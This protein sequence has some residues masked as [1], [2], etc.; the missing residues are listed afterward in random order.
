MGGSPDSEALGR[1]MEAEM[2]EQPAV[3]RGLL[4]SHTDIV[5]RVRRSI[6]DPVQ[7]IV[8]V[9]RGSSDNAAVF[10]RYVLESATL[11]PVS[12]LFPSLVTLYGV[13]ADYR[14]WV[15]IGA[16]QSGETPEIVESM[17]RLRRAGASAVA[18]TNDPSSP[19][20]ALSDV[21]VALGAG[22]EVAVPATKT[23]TS[24]LA[25]F[26]LL[27]EAMG[28]APWPRDALERVPAAVEAALADF[29]PV[30]GAAEALVDAP[31]AFVVGRGYML[32]VALEAALK[33]KESAAV[34]AEGIS[35][36]DLMHGPI[37][38]VQ[39]HT[40][41]VLLRAPGPTD[42]ELEE[43]RRRV[44]A[45]AARIVQV[46]AGGDVPL[47]GDLPEPLAVFPATV[48]AQ[49]LALAT[50]RKRGLDPDQPPGLAK[51]TR[52]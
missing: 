9:A 25:A 4:A 18:I 14:G 32:A 20:A 31:S 51:V 52:F 30:A 10:G 38:A 27:G 35:A 29:E 45:R 49:Q 46:G 44:E 11:R 28:K 23:F 34:F 40:R 7:G 6:P 2:G 19:L 16:S 36:A 13:A 22:E 47:P 3:L 43:V 5:D 39:P 17:E 26:A 21:T 8:L 42:E 37:A 1:N 41:V 33:L 50:A 24:Q 12:M 48:R 15:A